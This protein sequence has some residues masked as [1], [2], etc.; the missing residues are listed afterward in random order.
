MTVLWCT[1]SIFNQANS[2]WSS[3]CGIGKVSTSDGYGYH[4]GRK[5]RVLHKS[6][7]SRRCD[8]DCWHIDLVG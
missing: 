4:W 5:R 6:S 3:L 7:L 1:I 2:A 8:Q